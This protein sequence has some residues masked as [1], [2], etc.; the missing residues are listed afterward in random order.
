MQPVAMAAA[1]FTPWRQRS[2]KQSRDCGSIAN[3]EPAST[4]YGRKKWKKKK[5]EKKV[6][7]ILQYTVHILLLSREFRFFC[8]SW[9]TAI[10]SP[11]I[12]KRAIKIIAAMLFFV[13]FFYP[14]SIGD[15][16]VQHNWTQGEKNLPHFPCKTAVYKVFIIVQMTRIGRRGKFYYTKI[17]S[18]FGECK[19]RFQVGSLTLLRWTFAEYSIYQHSTS[20]FLNKVSR[21]NEQSDLWDRAVVRGNGV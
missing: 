1:V 2:Q 9:V 14:F 20:W 21:I 5:K 16:C 18:V 7:S 12:L 11:W 8:Q 6:L 17:L 10:M 13:S 15:L 4:E 3:K 19:K